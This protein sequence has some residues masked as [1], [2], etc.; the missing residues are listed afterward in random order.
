MDDRCFWFGLPLAGGTAVVL[1]IAVATAPLGCNPCVLIAAAL[2]FVAFAGRADAGSITY[3]FTGTF[4]SNSDTTGPVIPAGFEPGDPVT[5]GFTVD[6]A[7][8]GFYSY[9][10]S[11]S[12]YSDGSSNDFFY[13]A[14]LSGGPLLPDLSGSGGSRTTTGIPTIA[15]GPIPLDT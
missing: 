6:F 2:A 4:N 13:D 14:F 11:P 9:L 7:A 15:A 12:Y 8:P 5:Y 1:A 10:G 3:T